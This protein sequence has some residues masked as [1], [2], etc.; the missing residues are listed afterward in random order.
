MPC[1]WPTQ[2]G[3]LQGTPFASAIAPIPSLLCESKPTE[4]LRSLSAG[5][6]AEPSEEEWFGP[7]CARAVAEGEWQSGGVAGWRS[8]VL[9]LILWYFWG[10]WEGKIF[11]F[12]PRCA[13]GFWSHGARSR[14]CGEHLP[15]RR[16]P[17][18]AP[19]ILVHAFATPR[20]WRTSGSSH[21]RVPRC[22]LRRQRR[23]CPAL[24]P[25]RAHR[26]RRV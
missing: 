10:G 19:S 12:L 25:G 6:C 11:L 9:C 13:R 26:Q 2:R 1:L 14:D 24:R 18:P 22:V 17:F 4:R 3:A 21:P 8:A 7:V 16:F 23:T 15:A 5:E 20:H